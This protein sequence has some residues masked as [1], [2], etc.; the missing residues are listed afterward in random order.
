VSIS[1]SGWVRH[2][3]SRRIG[4]SCIEVALEGVEAVT[5]EAAVGREPVVERCQWCRFHRVQ[6]ALCVPAYGHQAGFPQHSQVLGCPRLAEPEPLDQFVHRPRSLQQEI[7][8]SSPVR[9]S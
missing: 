6:A 1:W 8:Q 2:V 3:G 9:V 4:G 7:E 5:P